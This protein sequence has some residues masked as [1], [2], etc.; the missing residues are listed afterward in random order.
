MYAGSL[1]SIPERFQTK[2]KTLLSP[3]NRMI[4]DDILDFGAIWA[5]D[6]FWFPFDQNPICCDLKST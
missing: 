2:P 4:L 3:M 6:T 1:R 5:D